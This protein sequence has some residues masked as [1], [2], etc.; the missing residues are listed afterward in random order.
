MCKLHICRYT[1]CLAKWQLQASGV[2]LI[3]SQILVCEFG[4]SFLQCFDTVD[5]VTHWLHTVQTT[6]YF[7]LVILL[8]VYLY[9]VEILY[10]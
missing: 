1:S 4:L 2:D 5:R 6:K 7:L 3:F 9:N 10:I 8:F